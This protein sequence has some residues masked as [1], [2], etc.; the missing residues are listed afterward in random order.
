M[1]RK[2]GHALL[3]FALIF[4]LGGHWVVLQAVAWTNMLATNLRTDSFEEA[5]TKTF[6]GQHPCKLCKTISAGKKSERKSELPTLAKKLEFVSGRSPFVFSAPQ[7]FRFQ[8]DLA[9]YFL[10]SRNQPPAPPPRCA[11]V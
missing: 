4:A 8:P 2:F 9:V 3:I 1:L 7:D 10:S 11:A 5:V 6:D